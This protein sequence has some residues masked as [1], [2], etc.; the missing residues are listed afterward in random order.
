MSILIN[1][2]EFLVE[3]K[4]KLIE[5]LKKNDI[6]VPNFCYDSRIVKEGSC[7]ICAVEVNGKL[8]KSCEIYTEDGMVV[9][10]H[11][12]EVIEERERI[13]NDI[14]ETHPLDCLT[15]HKSGHCKLQEYCYEYEIKQTHNFYED[16]KLAIDDSNP[17]YTIDPNKCIACGK[18]VGICEQNQCNKEIQLNEINGKLAITTR[19]GAKINDTLCMSCGNCVSI[20]PVGALTP[21]TKSNFRNWEVEM[22]RTTCSYCGVGCQ[23]DFAVKNNEIVDAFPANIAPNDGLLCVKGKF[24]YKFINSPDRLTKPL[25]RKDG[26]L[27]ETTYEEAYKYIIDKMKDIKSKHGAD[28]FAGLSSARCTN[29]D[30]FMF[31]KLFRGVI[32]TNNLDHCARL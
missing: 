29:E 1:G 30:N 14:I 5:F 10:T 31:Q 4:M 20:C 2:K 19:S 28:A 27:V 22:V 9:K 12:E 3:K 13:L 25:V 21:K 8:Q 16:E 32:G 11:T 15:C 17:F 7:G 26:K 24:G 6:E 23:I 18:C